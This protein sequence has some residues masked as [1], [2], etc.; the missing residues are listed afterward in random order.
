MPFILRI[1]GGAWTKVAGLGA[2]ILA[3]LGAV[4][5][6]FL[7]GKSEGRAIER[8]KQEKADDD[9][10]A[11]KRVRDAGIDQLSD[12]ELDRRLRIPEGK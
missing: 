6:I 12:D 3:V 4:G 10:L 8:Q 1:F 2:I 11:A 7:K 5:A 9:F